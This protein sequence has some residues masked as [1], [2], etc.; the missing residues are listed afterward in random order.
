MSAIIFRGIYACWLA[1]S[2]FQ[3]GGHHCGLR[4]RPG[5]SERANLLINCLNVRQWQV[6]HGRNFRNSYFLTL[7]C[8]PPSSN[9]LFS[10]S[11]CSVE[12]HILLPHNS[13]NRKKIALNF[14]VTQYNCDLLYGKYLFPF[15][16][17]N[18]DITRY[19][20]DSKSTTIILRPQNNTE[21]L[22][23]INSKTLR[24]RHKGYERLVSNDV[25]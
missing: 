1:E 3:S 24:F 20:S 7:F 9:F 11:V 4:I 22:Y 19:T 23:K 18:V 2:I 13:C 16:N 8:P 15:K 12:S 14:Q 25:F 17:N 6:I 10:E 5:R 21:S